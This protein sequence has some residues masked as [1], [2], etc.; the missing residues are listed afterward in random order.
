MSAPLI[1]LNGPSSSGKTSIIKALQ[2]I[3]PRPLFTSGIDA[4][5]VG[6]PESHVTFPGEDGSPAPSSGMRIVSGLGPAPSWIPEYGDEFHAVLQFAHE[7]WAA[8]SRGGID[9]IIDHVMIDA[10]IR[11]H[12]RKTLADAFWVGVTCDIGELVRREAARGDRHHGFASGTSA[13]AHQ[14]MSYN[15]VVDTTTTAVDVLAG[16]IYE[17]VIG[18]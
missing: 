2:E 4:F 13:V 10:V 5:I 16:Q 3:W 11:N 1:V 7:S 14:E 18:T 17:A 9:L 12:A 15:L 8:M 6:W